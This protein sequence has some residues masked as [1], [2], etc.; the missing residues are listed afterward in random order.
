MIPGKIEGLDFTNKFPSVTLSCTYHCLKLEFI[1]KN[2][3]I[4]GHISVF[5]SE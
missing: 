3:M 4:C 1:F 2:E 5:D